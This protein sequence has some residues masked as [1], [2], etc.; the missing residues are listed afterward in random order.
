MNLESFDWTSAGLLTSLQTIFTHA[1]REAFPD[2]PFYQLDQADV[3]RCNNANRGDFQC[4]NAL[5]LGKALKRID[6]Y[7]GTNRH[8][9]TTL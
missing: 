3:A 2:T 8:L 5:A 7:T 1:I 6:G 4:N 9:F